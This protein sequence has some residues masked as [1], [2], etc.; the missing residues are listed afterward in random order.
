MPLQ[1]NV[2]RT[3]RANI[4]ITFDGP[5]SQA[6]FLAGQI[7]KDL[8]SRFLQLPGCRNKSLRP[9]IDQQGWQRRFPVT[10]KSSLAKIQDAERRGVLQARRSRYRALRQLMI[11][12]SWFG[13]LC[14]RFGLVAV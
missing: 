10:L 8:A 14:L 4:H 12:R 1:A 7:V 5:R 2:T 6:N 13:R 9:S 3:P 11:P